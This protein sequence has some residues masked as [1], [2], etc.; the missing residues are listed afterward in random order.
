[1]TQL[2][3]KSKTNIAAKQNAVRRIYERLLA[4]KR[5]GIKAKPFERD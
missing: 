3:D 5:Q 4:Y 2:R 1:M